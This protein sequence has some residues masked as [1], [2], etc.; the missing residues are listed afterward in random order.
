MR[1]LLV[2]IAC[3]QAKIWDKNP[4]AGRTLRAK[5]GFTSPDFPIPCCYN[6]TFKD[7][8]TGAVAD[9]ELRQQVEEM[10]LDCFELVIVLGGK[11]YREKVQAAFAGLPVK[12]RFPF[13]GLPIGKAAH[14][15]KAA[16]QAD[17]PFP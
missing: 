8:T 6:V 15:V 2:V 17:S 1:G 14:A 12:L 13:A 16:I 11:E 4:D 9:S 5:Y 7:P 10:H 3:G